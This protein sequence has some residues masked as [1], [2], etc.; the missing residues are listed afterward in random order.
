MAK[1]ASKDKRIGV[2]DLFG[3]S[4]FIKG[5]E[6]Q[7]DK[8]LKNVRS[9][10]DKN[11]RKATQSLNITTKKDLNSINARLKSIE[12]RL[13]KLEQ[14]VKRTS[15]KKSKPMAIEQNKPA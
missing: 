5:V 1:K 6:K 4:G 9:T 15:S 13:K 2:K 12:S 11:F 8:Q 14:A 7:L 3:G 10:L